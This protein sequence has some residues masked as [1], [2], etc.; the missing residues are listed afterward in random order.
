MTP[1]LTPEQ[2]AALDA[3]PGVPLRVVDPRT[4]AVYVLIPM[5]HYQKVQ[6]LFDD[7]DYDLSETYPAQMESAMRAGWADPAMDDYNDY[8]AHR[9]RS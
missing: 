7:A 6:T 3:Q 8:D 4:D 9:S 5:E 1:M 2:Q